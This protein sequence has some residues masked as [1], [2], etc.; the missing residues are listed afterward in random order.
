MVGIGLLGLGAQLLC[1]ALLADG[2]WWF[3]Q[4]K[5]VFALPGPSSPRSP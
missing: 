4:E 5:A 3:V 2:G 1:T